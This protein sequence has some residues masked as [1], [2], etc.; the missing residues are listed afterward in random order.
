MRKICTTKDIRKRKSGATKYILFIVAGILA[1]SSIFMTVETTT[2]SLEVSELRQKQTELSFE[3]RNLENTLVRSLSLNDL[4]E[5]G[6]EM[7]FTKP[8]TLVFVSGE[9]E[10][11]AKL[12]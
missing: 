4:Q 7:G 3:K 9:K 11:V 8:Q 12:P 2:S 1:V 5:K 6:G 10:A